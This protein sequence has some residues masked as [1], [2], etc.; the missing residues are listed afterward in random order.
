MRKKTGKVR[1]CNDLQ[2]ASKAV[3]MDK[4]VLPHAEGL[5]HKLHD[6]KYFSKI[7]LAA[8]YQ[9][10]LSPESGDLTAFMTDDRPI[11]I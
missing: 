8:P 2:E 9:V 3:V 1:L 5:L 10:V 6:A 11:Q 7:D 4:F